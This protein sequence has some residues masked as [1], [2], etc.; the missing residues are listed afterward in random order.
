MKWTD[1][2]LDRVLR[3]LGEEDIPANALVSVRARVAERTRRTG[4]PWLRWA[5]APAAAVVLALV[6]WPEPVAVDPP[7][8]LASTPAVP[9]VAWTKTE[10]RRLPVLRPPVPVERETQFI[11]LFTDDPDVVI[12]WSLETKGDE[13]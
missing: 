7:P 3:D 1:E 4:T 5:W 12:L 13:E 10:K 2:D 11:R 9:E 6:L 8:L